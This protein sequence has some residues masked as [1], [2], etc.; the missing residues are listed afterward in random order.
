MEPLLKRITELMR[1]RRK[2]MRIRSIVTCL[3]AVVVFAT[4]YT[5]ILPAITMNEETA[6]MEPGLV[7]AQEKA[8]EETEFLEEPAETEIL[9][10][11]EE[12][13]EEPAEET[14]EE[15][16]AEEEDLALEP[17][18]SGAAM[19]EDLDVE[20]DRLE[21][22]DE[23]AEDES[24][25]TMTK[26]YEDDEIEIVATYG[27]EANIPEEAE[28]LAKKLDIQN[29]EDAE[30][31]EEN[32][33]VERCRYDIGFYVN[34]EEIEPEATV[35]IQVSFLTDAF[36][37][38]EDMTIVHY[39]DDNNPDN[40]E[41]IQQET[42][43]DENGNVQVEFDLDSFSIVEFQSQTMNP[44]ENSETVAVEDEPW[45]LA[46]SAYGESTS[47]IVDPKI[48]HEKY[49]SA[50][51]A[52]GTYDLSLTVSST[53]GSE[54]SKVPMD[55]VLIIDRSGS[56][57]DENRLENAQNAANSLITTLSQNDNLDARYNIV[58]FSG[59]RDW[60]TRAS[61]ENAT[62]DG[63][64]DSAD[65]AKDR[66][67]AIAADGGTNY[68]AAFHQAN[69]Q[70]ARAL[71]GAQTVVIFLT[72]GEATARN[73]QLAHHDYDTTEL[74]RDL[75]AG[76]TAANEIHAT[77]FYAIAT[78]EAST[79]SLAMIRNAV[80]ASQKGVYSTSN[81]T[82]LESIF[83][84]IASSVTK[85]SAENVTITDKL[86]E[87]VELTDKELTVTVKD[88]EGNIINTPAGITASVSD[89]KRTIQLNFPDDYELKDGYTYIVTANIRATE[90]AYE[91]YRNNNN[92][93]PDTGD[94]G[95][96]EDERATS[97]EKPGVYTNDGATVSYT[98][99]EKSYSED[100]AKPVIQLHPGKLMIEKEFE[101]LTGEEIKELANQ[102]T[103]TVKLKETEYTTVTLSQFT[104][105]SDGS[106][107]YCAAEGL[108]PDTSYEVTE[109]GQEVGGYDCTPTEADTTGTVP[110]DETKTAHFQNSYQHSAIGIN[111]RKVASGEGTSENPTYLSG[112]EFKLYG[113]DTDGNK[114]GDAL[115]TV[116]SDSTG[117]CS[118]GELQAGVYILE[119]TKAPDGYNLLSEP[120]RITVSNGVVTVNNTSGANPNSVEKREDGTYT[121]TISNSAGHQL[122]NT[123][124][125]GTLF[126]TFSGLAII[127]ICLMT[128]FSMR[129]KQERRSN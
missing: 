38:A 120:I 34:G 104:E 30:E 16:P 86:N 100:Y 60:R 80:N 67:Y 122:P 48:T 44:S 96:N 116:T 61:D 23:T 111:I 29:T 24:E 8:S 37:D 51:K 46:V 118:L 83:E 4:T 81:T 21:L 94:A 85:I 66:V 20:G 9:N 1:N 89:D 53:V 64:T 125:S 128:G 10:D 112:A 90:T 7:L 12:L 2:N 32:A 108:S 17:E 31:T 50:E 70:L 106:Y 5:L 102:L 121:I 57:K 45:N 74:S 93:Y 107:T 18:S 52:D 11:M 127:A 84:D 47:T 26:T 119:E 75:Q 6:E 82:S 76:V 92:S 3:A 103:F 99:N 36:D 123:G 124:G 97:A 113:S 73:G 126:Y 71:S 78:G 105:N 13:T 72:D 98:V 91:K 59:P 15:I 19:L 62:S 42:K 79:E 69:N 28:F 14:I 33:E 63:W 95:T 40:T 58:S 27:K 49:V 110:K 56:M 68:E 65:T 109:S 77:Y 54:T 129:R 41:T 55:V 101:G 115:Q 87:N 43:E 88:A 114:T 35:S 22:I 117:S 39:L 25:E